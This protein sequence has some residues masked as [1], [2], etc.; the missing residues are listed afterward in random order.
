[1]EK[2]TRTCQNCKQ[3]FMIEPED[4]GFYKKMDVPAP[5]FC[6]DCR[7][8]R[9]LAFRNE[10]ALYKRKCDLTR[11]D[12]ISVHSQ[13]SGFIVY[14]IRDWFSDKWDAATY[15]E[16]PDFSKTF[17]DQ[18]HNFMH[19]VPRMSLMLDYPTITNS[20]YN[21]LAGHLK[22]CY[23]VSE[24]D[25]N[26]N[27]AYANSIKHSKDS[28]DILIG[29]NLELSY[30][31]INCR[32]CNRTLFSEDCED[33]FNV[34]FSK[35]LVGCSNC[36]GCVGLR[37]KQYHIFNQ[38]YAQEEYRKKLEELRLDSRVSLGEIRK[39][40]LSLWEKF[41]R[42]Y[43]HGRH[44]TNVSGDYI[45]FS[46]NSVH[47]N[48]VVGVED[49][50]YCDIISL[51]P[52]RGCYDYTEWGNNAESLYE[53]L[54]VGEGANSIRFSNLVW[55]SVR[56][57]EYSMECRNSSNLFGCIGLNNKQYCIFN[58]QYS[59]EK[60]NEL[61]AKLIRHMDDQPYVDKN[62]IIY[63]Y[64]EFFP[65]ALSPFAYNET[66]AQDFL[67]LTKETAAE[68]GYRWKD[69]KEKNYQITKKFQDIPGDIKDVTDAFLN[70][71]IE[72]QHRGK[73]NH[74]CTSAFKLISSEL[75]FYRSMNIPLPVLCSNCRH[76]ERIERRNPRKY[77]HRKCACGGIVSENNIY[78]NTTSHFHG[79][80]PCPNEFETS[81]APDRPEI[82]YCEAC[83]N[84]EVT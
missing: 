31:C 12:I 15:G 17:F 9:R 80:E 13:D 32:K 4:F 83:Y 69:Q 7:L 48:E 43:M 77:W 35:D 75:S 56:K 47:C 54:T 2:E 41:P 36:V 52:A 55:T 73:C 58:K 72:C 81:Y 39:K 46:K 57:V 45:Y 78:Q 65:V 20:D 70:D 24:A 16:D 42:K 30:E 23:L 53:C 74:Q 26:E 18:F 3:D 38:P 40:A 27:C 1:M 21:N 8:Q 22:N 62:G 11:Q 25:F 61:R 44:N 28:F 60:F 49:S 10:K 59:E 6:P 14:N 51:K 71:I 66:S 33:C 63:K 68:R 76:G 34:S 19:A 64:G 29:Q 50:K 82:V 5:T 67:P 84:S 37:K 79:A